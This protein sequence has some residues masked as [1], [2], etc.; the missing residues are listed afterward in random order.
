MADGID[1]DARKR[2]RP[3]LDGAAASS[4]GE[5]AAVPSSS[6][7]GTLLCVGDME[8]QEKEGNAPENV[9]VDQRMR[10]GLRRLKP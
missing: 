8:E 4:S 3:S 1:S 10:M 7:A 9:A 2:K 6:T 5:P